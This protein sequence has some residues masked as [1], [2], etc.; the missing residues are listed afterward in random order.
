M[1]PHEVC[2]TAEYSVS[3]AKTSFGEGAW[4]NCGFGVEAAAGTL[5][6]HATLPAGSALGVTVP[7]CFG[8]SFGVGEVETEADGV[9]VAPAV[10]V[11]FRLSSATPRAITRMPA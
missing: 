1:S 8:G 10:E 4:S 6:P 9:G 2:T 5:A 7:V 11:S 3:L